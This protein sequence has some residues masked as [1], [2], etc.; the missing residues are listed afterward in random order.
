ME[1]TNKYILSGRVNTNLI[2][3]AINL[4]ETNSQIAYEY[5]QKF[6]MSEENIKRF[7]DILTKFQINNLNNKNIEK[8]MDNREI[9]F[10]N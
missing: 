1:L 7:Y 10:F 9:F 8:F 6:G 5:V 4:D 2:E 3:Q